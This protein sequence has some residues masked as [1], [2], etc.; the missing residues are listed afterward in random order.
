[1]LMQILLS[2]LGIREVIK[3]TIFVPV[4]YLLLAVRELTM[5]NVMLLSIK[6]DLVQL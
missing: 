6:K 3:P 2:D 4:I 1:M 5:G